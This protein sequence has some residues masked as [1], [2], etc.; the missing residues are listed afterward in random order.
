MESII[1]IIALENDSEVTL[2]EFVCFTFNN[3]Y[4][5][6]NSRGQIIRK[7]GIA[8]TTSICTVCC[9]LFT[10]NVF[11]DVSNLP[12]HFPFSLF[13]PD[14]IYFLLFL[15]SVKLQEGNELS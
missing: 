14:F 9:V 11:K 4:H 12:S 10:S 5:Q 15:Q 13:Y 1:C 7:D 2:R 6:L 8:C 3:V